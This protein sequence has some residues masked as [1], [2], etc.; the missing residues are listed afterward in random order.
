M[1]FYCPN[2]TRALCHANEILVEDQTPSAN[3]II[4]SMDCSLL[5]SYPWKGCGIL[6]GAQAASNNL[7]PGR[8]ISK[9]EKEPCSGLPKD[10][11]YDAIKK[12]CRRV[13]NNRK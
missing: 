9:S 12:T 8:C 4:E 10:Y 2:G 5:T 6:F 11:Q 3:D 13:S 1:D 7:P